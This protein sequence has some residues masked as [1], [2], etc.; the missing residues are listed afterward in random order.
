MKI[1][2]LN[3]S[4][5]YVYLVIVEEK[6]ISLAALRLNI[7]QSAVSQSLKRLEESLEVKLI[8]RSNKQFTLTKH[9]EYLHKVAIDIYS[10]LVKVEQR[11]EAGNNYA[12]DVLNVMMV[13]GIASESFDRLLTYFHHNYPNIQLKITAM[14]NAEI[15]RKLT[16][17]QPGIAL[18]LDPKGHE[19]VESVFYFPQRYSFYCGQCH[20]LFHKD[21]IFKSDVISQDYVIFES[22]QLGAALS[23]IAIFRDMEHFSGKVSAVANNLY[24]LRRLIIAGYG[25]GCL[26]D[27]AAEKEVQNG[28]L[29]K[30]PP[31]QGVADIPIYFSW[32]K[33]RKLKAIEHAFIDAASMVLEPLA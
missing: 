13:T 6:S 28:R 30:L 32:A 29:R 19:D 11:L 8:E 16:A 17:N 10:K 23:P 25:I 1:D 15:I 33:K 21:E 7:T 26:P 5:I 31:Y 9:G 22:E 18:T 4:L 20:P 14:S 3:W 27:N 2:R 12:Q 24:E